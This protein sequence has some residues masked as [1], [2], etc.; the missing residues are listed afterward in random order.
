MKVTLEITKD[1][2]TWTVL[3]RHGDVVATRTM[4]RE[5]GGFR[6]TAKG[7]VFEEALDYNPLLEAIEDGDAHSIA[8][9]LDCI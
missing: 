9:V 4:L 2:W 6:S 7:S 5:K 3:D 8:N 1:G